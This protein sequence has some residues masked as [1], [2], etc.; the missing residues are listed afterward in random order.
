MPVTRHSRN[1]PKSFTIIA[2]GRE[3]VQPPPEPP[4]GPMGTAREMEEPQ[5]DVFKCRDYT[6]AVFND[7][8]QLF[9]LLKRP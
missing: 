8:Q 1:C 5:E 9:D 6:P 3:W 4:T 7:L 2:C